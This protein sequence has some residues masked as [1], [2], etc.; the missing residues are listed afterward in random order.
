MARTY[1]AK[2]PWRK[3][4]RQSE[5]E[6]DRIF[7]LMLRGVPI[8][9]IAKRMSKNELMVRDNYDYI[10]DNIISDKISNFAYMFTIQFLPRMNTGLGRIFDRISFWQKFP[11]DDHRGL[12][13][14]TF[15][16]SLSPSLDEIRTGEKSLSS[17]FLKSLAL[18][19]RCVKCPF[20]TPSGF[21]IS[22]RE[23]ALF[24][25]FM[26]RFRN[27]R[28]NK[29]FRSCIELFKI[30]NIMSAY[31]DFL[32]YAADRLPIEYVYSDEKQRFVRYNFRKLEVALKKFSLATISQFIDNHADLP[33]E[34]TEM[35]L[36]ASGAV[37]AAAE[38]I[39]ESR[40][41]FYHF[42]EFFNFTWDNFESLKYRYT[43]E[44]VK[45]FLDREMRQ[46]TRFRIIPVDPSELGI[47]PI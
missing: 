35:D 32:S 28:F 9:Q 41:D 39:E 30:I 38:S 6:F 7:F 43:M 22:E 12:Y 10:V 25:I 36:E 33:A 34:L 46:L 29:K 5:A 2:N 3:G 11:F 18:K 16:C 15:N 1:F 37:M 42:K 20:R 45:Y 26:K 40:F 8:S 44:E 27:I 23:H 21:K 14:C 31:Y 19:S 47:R 13:D 17:S 4:S 24:L